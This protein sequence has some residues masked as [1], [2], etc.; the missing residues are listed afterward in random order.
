MHKRRQKAARRSRQSTR[1]ESTELAGDRHP[2]S[3]H[4]VVAEKYDLYVNFDGGCWPNPG[5]RATWGI[6]V[7]NSA[8]ET[9]LEASGVV[10]SG[11]MMSNNVAEYAAALRALQAIE[12][13]AA[14]GWKVLL[15]GDSQIVIHK[16]DSH[17]VSRGLCHDACVEAQELFRTLKRKGILICLRWVP[18]EENEPADALTD[19]A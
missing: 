16:L 18:R 2:H 6:V 14:P 9:V 4:A 10:G 5:G 11:P 15:R 12:D 19:A 8:G 3:E 1:V 7:Q 13:L 17:H